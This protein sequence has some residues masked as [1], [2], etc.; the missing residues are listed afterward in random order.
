M[1]L[2]HWLSWLFSDSWSALLAGSHEGGSSNGTL[3]A[4]AL[5]VLMT[6]STSEG[7]VGY[8]LYRT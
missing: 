8:S 3:I 5:A 2:L 7:A 1:R 6:N 4:V